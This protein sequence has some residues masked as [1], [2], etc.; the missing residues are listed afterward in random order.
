MRFP[1]RA[2]RVLPALVATA[3]VGIA[4]TARADIT[5]GIDL[6]STGPAAAIGIAS[7]NAMQLWPAEI[8]G[9]KAHYIFL[10][11]GSDPG[12]AV[13]NTRKLISEDKVDVIVGPNVTAS[14][15]AMLD[16]ISEA[17]TPMVSLIGSAIAVEPAQDPKKR[18]AF[19]MAAND[20]AMADVMTRYMANHGIKTVAFIGF[21]DAYGESWW[22]EFSKFAALRKI[23]I[24]GQERFN[25]TDT[26]VTGQVLKVMSAKP[27]AIL[28]AGSGTPAAL[29]Q[30]TLQE[31]GYTGKIYQTHGIAT[32]DFI[33][34]GG[35]DVEG[36]LFPTQPGV[37]AKTLPA[38]H[39][40]AKAALAFT[41]KY[42]AKYGVD[43]VTQFA[44]DAY[45]VWD[46]LNNAVPRAAKTAQP[47]TPAFR[48][49]LRDALENTHN[50]AIPNGIMN[51][52][53]AD[54]VGL[55]Q[56]AGVMGQ[57]KGGKFVYVGD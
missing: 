51:T 21:A 43:T 14:A 22:N 42:E 30:R 47:G 7:K 28:I 37:V 10:D 16:P 6:S 40:A 17:Q 53:P 12:N 39:P 13:K 36:T 34:V 44:A 27:D 24:V 8:G 38:D 9:Q 41:K 56:R 23:K 1:Y 2:S 46:L 26:S 4:T 54:H 20:S 32:Y 31:R 48:V 15:L 55:D 52:S 50:L 19:K 29:P 49:A 45:G 57:I 33:R 3:L 11:D 5:V 35:K 18:W 25:R